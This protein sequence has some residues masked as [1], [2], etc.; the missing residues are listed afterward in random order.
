MGDNSACSNVSLS[1]ADAGKDFDLVSDLLQRN[2]IRQSANGIN[3]DLFVA[4]II[5]VASA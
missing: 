4:H 3:D 1:A 2:I 5:N